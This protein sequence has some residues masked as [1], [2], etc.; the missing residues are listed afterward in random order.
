MARPLP[1]VLG[2][3]HVAPRR[4]PLDAQQGQAEEQQVEQQESDDERR[5]AEAGEYERRPHSVARQLPGWRADV[6]PKGMPVIVHST[7]APMATEAVTG[8]RSRI[9]SST[10]RWL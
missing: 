4:E 1:R 9:V 10:G 2:E 3:R 8:R 5:E 7:A 6:T